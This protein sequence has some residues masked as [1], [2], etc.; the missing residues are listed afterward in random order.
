M[1]SSIFLTPAKSNPLSGTIA[2]ILEQSTIVK[3]IVDSNKIKI[4]SAFY[5]IETGVVTFLE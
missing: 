1:I 5:D 4:V 3:D 2:D